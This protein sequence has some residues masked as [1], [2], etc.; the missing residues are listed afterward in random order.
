MGQLF[1]VF[2]LRFLAILKIP[3]FVYLNILNQIWRPLYYIGD[4]R[5]I[6]EK[7][8]VMILIYT[9]YNLFFCK[10]YNLDITDNTKILHYW[11]HFTISYKQYRLYI[12]N[13]K[14]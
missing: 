7:L 5:N 13:D 3:T 8:E 10:Y 4:P 6:I 14:Q 1:D 9:K 2:F 11:F 12:E